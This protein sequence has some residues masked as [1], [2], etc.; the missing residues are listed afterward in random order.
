M[1]GV[2]NYNYIGLIGELEQKTFRKSFTQTMQGIYSSRLTY[3]PF[4]FGSHVL[5]PKENIFRMFYYNSDGEVNK[6]Y[7]YTSEGNI[8][9]KEEYEFNDKGKIINSKFIS[10]DSIVHENYHYEKGKIKEYYFV[11]HKWGRAKKE[12]YE[13]D[14]VGRKLKKTNFGLL[15]TEEQITDYFY[16]GSA[17][18]YNFR[19]VSKPDGTLI[20]TFY[21]TYDSKE[22]ITGMFGFNLNPDEILALIKKEKGGN[23]WEL[24][25]KYRSVWEYQGGN[26]VAFKRDEIAHG[27]PF[28]DFG[29]VSNQDN[30]IV[31]QQSISKFEKIAGKDHLIETTEY[32]TWFDEP[33]AVKLY[34]YFDKSG[35]VIYQHPALLD[36]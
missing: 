22:N 32:Q 12:I 16:D 10:T 15:G 35:K 36:I 33:L 20:M 14:K 27:H 8:E 6:K 9:M 29:L 24:V 5:P 3:A 19:R 7:S 25:S 13:Y 2:Q 4:A 30:R 21:F 18:K 31:T 23:Q 17:K 11:N 28:L 26:P 34:S 1:E